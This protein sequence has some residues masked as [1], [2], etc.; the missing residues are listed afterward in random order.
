MLWAE[1]KS[2]RPCLQISPKLTINW[3]KNNEV[4]ICQ[5][6]FIAKLFWRC[7]IPFIK[8]VTGPSLMAIPL[9]FLKI[10]KLLYIKEMN[11]NRNLKI[12]NALPEFCL[13][14]EDWSNSGISNWAWMFLMTSYLMLLNARFKA[15]TISEVLRK[16]Y[17][18]EVK[19]PSPNIY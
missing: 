3:K 9:L 5:R 10:R 2:Y 11:K 8:L 18:G 14:S 1:F 4:I 6:D 12:K 7:H 19:I 13:I 16:N 15:F 17:Q